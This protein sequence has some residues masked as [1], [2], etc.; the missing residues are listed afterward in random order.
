MKKLDSILFGV[1]CALFFICGGT[2][3]FYLVARTLE[4]TGHELR[5]LM[6]NTLGAVLLTLVIILVPLAVTGAL[7]RRHAVARW[8][9]VANFS[10]GIGFMFSTP[11][12]DTPLYT[13]S[14]IMVNR[15][16]MCIPVVLAILYLLLYFKK[17]K[18]EPPSE[19]V[20]ENRQ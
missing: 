16:I 11:A 6:L 20:P 15:C 5:A 13:A 19:S 17:R 4:S 8:I 1:I 3:W 2:T 12:S 18:I 7:W 14:Q 10:V 9:A